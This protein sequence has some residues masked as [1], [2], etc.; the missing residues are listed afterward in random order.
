MK[1]LN[2]HIK[3]FRFKPVY[4]L[5]GQEGY[6]KRQYRDRIRKAVLG[7]DDMNYSHYEGAKMDIRDCIDTCE[8][9]PFF[10]DSRVVVIE[11]TGFF[12]NSCD[13]LLVDYVKNIPEY[14][15]I[16]FVESEVDKRNRLYKAVTANG[17][18]A[19]LNMQDEKMLER[20]IVQLSAAD[21]KTMEK[22]ALRRF[23]GQTAESMDNMKMELDKLMSYC[24][25]RAVITEEDVAAVCTEV[26]ENRIFDMIAAVGMK[27]QKRAMELYYDLCT[28]KEPP[29]RILAL[30][31]RQFNMLYQTKLLVKDGYDSATIA[32]KLG[33]M[34]FVAGKYM[35]QAKIYTLSSLKEAVCDCVEAEEAVK[36]GKLNDTL[37][38]EMIIVKY[39]S[40][41]EKE[42]NGRKEKQ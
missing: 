31:E 30:I 7:E 21:G 9:L 19:E 6:L 1:I 10:A 29:L 4:L 37:S 24:G 17:Y 22:P 11:N 18:A 38:I 25:D 23:L 8:T 15:H 27:N 12:K 14:L 36:T 41:E 40:R 34:A 35:E 39:S 5:Y 3:E 2:E 42:N 28:L 33:V 26:T 32:K 13:D 20:W 16:I